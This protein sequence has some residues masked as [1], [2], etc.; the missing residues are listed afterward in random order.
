M[1][2]MLKI[3]LANIILMVIGFEMIDA[4]VQTVTVQGFGSSKILAINDAKRNA[5]EEGLGAIIASE[6][7]IRNANLISDKIISRA[8]GF[9]KNYRELESKQDSDGMYSITIEAEVTEIIDEV[10]KDQIAL[11]LLLEW[12]N[13]PRFLV[14]INERLLDDESSIIAE[15]E[16]SK[17]LKEKNFNLVSQSQVDKVRDR[18]KTLE[19]SQEE[20]TDGLS[21]IVTDFGAEIFVRG[22]ADA[23]VVELKGEFFADTGMYSGQASITASVIRIDTGNILAVNTFT[24]K[25]IHISKEIAAVNALI[26]A[27]QNLARY[28]L[29]E[30]IRTWSHE[31][32]NVRNFSLSIINV[33]FE[34]RKSI[35]NFLMTLDGIQNVQRVSFGSGSAVLSIDYLGGVLDELAELLNGK[36]MGD[37]VLEVTGDSPGK[38]VLNLVEK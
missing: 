33:N 25:S 26:E 38:L 2:V 17:I 5:V 37:F 32:S 11:D 18:V 12:L 27:S 9:V 13:K 23:S 29:E 24:G 36:D 21:Q 35:E 1:G 3:F 15:A 4:Q 19:Y 28:L 16:I 7:L 31:Q 30:T 14:V 20:K 8:N 22:K 6:T 10:L 34:R